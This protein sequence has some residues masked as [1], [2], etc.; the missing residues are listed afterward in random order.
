M[1]WLSHALLS[2]ALLLGADHEALRAAW[3]EHLELDR[4]AEVVR[5]SE[6]AFAQDAE[7]SADGELVALRARAL[8][9]TGS[10]D[11]AR[12]LL[13][14]AHPS[15]ATR[16]AIELELARL[17]LEADQLGAVTSRLL[18]PSKPGTPRY[19]ERAASWVLLGK[20]LSRRGEDTLAAELLRHFVSTW[21]LH[22]EAP[23]AWHVLAQEA[24]ARRDVKAATFCR[25]RGR[26]LSTWHGFYR[27][28][29]LQVEAE[30][31]APLPRLGLAQLWLSVEELSPARAALLELTRRCPDFARGFATLGEV[32]RKLGSLEAALQAYGQ[33]LELDAALHDV[34]FN[35]GLL[36]LSR[37]DMPRARQD[38]E[39]L[40]DG[41]THED[42]RYALAHL[43][44]ARIAK[45]AGD[46]EGAS[47]RY[48][49]YRALGGSEPLGD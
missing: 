49:A 9:A 3:Q 40:A 46:D 11:G 12:A 34:R 20:A 27:T 29:R 28:R 21:R 35:R 42:P 22:P 41:P 47:Q 17:D 43:H 13:D 33:A 38:F 8:A 15:E 18:D 32:E 6:A 37:D 5:Q 36:A 24:L 31:D 4:A 48:A 1:S 25:D 23:S 7:L 39:L 14:R 45:R 2:L 10:A 16:P 19:S 44:L 26:E 30:P